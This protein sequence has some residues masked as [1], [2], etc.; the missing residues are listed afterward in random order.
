MKALLRCWLF[1]LINAVVPLLLLSPTVIGQR[2]LPDDN[3]AYP[4]LV[5]IP[6]VEEASG[7]YVN[8]STSEY[9]VTA[10]HVLFDNKGQLLGSAM[11]LLSYPKDPNERVIN[12]YS[13]D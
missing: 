9:F 5:Q 7:F 13:I 10:K 12:R 3:L 1:P 6:G 4:V 2:A 8:T 11:T